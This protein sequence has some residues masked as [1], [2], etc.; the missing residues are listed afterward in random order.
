MV[1]KLSA[2]GDFIQAL[3]PMKAIRA[4]HKEAE[5]TLLTTKP[6]ESF[7]KQAGYVDKV[8]L[9]PRPKWLD[10]SDWLSLRRSLRTKQYDAV[11]D[12][13]NNGRVKLYKKLLKPGFIWHSI[14]NKQE[15]KEHASTRHKKILQRAGITKAVTPDTMSWAGK[16]L[17]FR[18]LKLP[19]KFVLL[20][21]GCAPQ[22]PYK[23][24]PA[25]YY[26]QLAKTLYDDHGLTAVIIGTKAEESEAH[27]IK[28]DCPE[29]IS[30][31][32]QTKLFDIPAL[33]RKAQ[34]AVGNDTGPMHM[35]GPTN[36]KSLVLFSYASDPARHAP[37]GKNIETLREESLTDLLPSVVLGKLKN[38]INDATAK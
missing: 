17:D 13:Q 36:C 24:W 12:L 33:A 35:I 1:I 19:K 3:G 20:V 26:G 11:Y 5:I 6:F 34:F 15:R 7:A 37:L 14:L 29:T 2:L 23:R 22:H 28:E 38:W 10:F 8:I 16:D 4:H 31:I 27:T 25:H 18:S 32:G 30:L 21:P 9:D